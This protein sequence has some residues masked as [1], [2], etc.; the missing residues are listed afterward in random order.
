M[1]P[2]ISE[3]DLSLVVTYAI[4]GSRRDQMTISETI[5]LKN[6]LVQL[7]YFEMAMPDVI[8]FMG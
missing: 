8:A 6:D 7:N 4:K 1:I 2:K 3:K 5:S